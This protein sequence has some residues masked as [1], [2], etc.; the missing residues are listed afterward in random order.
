MG[1]DTSGATRARLCVPIGGATL[2]NAAVRPV[3]GDDGALMKVV[4]ASIQCVKEGGASHFRNERLTTKEH[5]ARRDL[6]GMR[7]DLREVQV[8]GQND[9]GMLASEVAY[10]AILSRNAPTDDQWPA[11]RPA[12]R[13]KQPSEASGSD[14]REAAS[15]CEPD[16]VS[17][18]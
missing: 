4:L 14:R 5:D 12:V 1:D 9:V 15:A 11:P 6:P 18:S 13:R 16:L 17:L 3:E 2:W 8:V 10:I 7:E